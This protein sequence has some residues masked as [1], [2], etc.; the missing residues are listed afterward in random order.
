[1]L[2]F[3]LAIV[4]LGAAGAAMAQTPTAANCARAA[5]AIDK[6]ICGNAGLQEADRKL[7]AAYRTLQGTL[8]GKAREHLASDQ[9]RWLANRDKA[10]VGE[11]AEI[12]DCLDTR[13]RDRR[14][15]LEWL[16][17]GTYPLISEQAIVT[18]GKA[19]GIP[20]VI[21]ASYP[22]FDATSTDFSALNRQIESAT[23]EAADRVVPGPDADNGGGNYT[24]P[25]WVYEQ[26]Y[27]LH[28]P[29]PN[30]VTV[31]VR[32]D[33]Y[34]GGAH[35]IVGVSGVLVDLRT[36]KAVG[37]D[38]VFLPTSNWLREITRIASADIGAT[39]LAD[40]L[41]DPRRYVFLE[42]H[43]ELSFGPQE[44]GPYTV[45]IP[46]DRLRPMLRVDGPVPR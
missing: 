39:N 45:E 11:P 32:Y 26:A 33:S 31:Y 13:L 9:A 19:K 8:T 17:D 21:D 4:L 46:Y 5:T 27:T 42:D 29:G 23:S 22:Q 24:G 44:G 25:A 30:A 12:E 28:R 15:R 3:A 35:G 34:E 37:P 6:A 41:K 18:V 20:Y 1:M 16:A 36:G 10:C 2:R 38:G 14:A 43:L 40:L 7:S